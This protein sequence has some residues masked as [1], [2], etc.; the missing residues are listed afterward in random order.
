MKKD[1][2]TGD[3]F[4]PKRTNQK[5]KCAENRIKFNNRKAKD[6]REKM[7]FINKPLKDSFLILN[8]LMKNKKEEVF[9]KEFLK[10]K[11]ISFK[12]FTHYQLI[13]GK[14]YPS[15]YDYTLINLESNHIKVLKND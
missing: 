7:N 2:L 12:I 3:N 9:H 14:S 15:I 10:G 13:D 8:E 11:G 1:L 5:F 6:R 4:K